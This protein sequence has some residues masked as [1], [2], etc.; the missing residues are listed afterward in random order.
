M[1]FMLLP[2]SKGQGRRICFSTDVDYMHVGMVLDHES[3]PFPCLTLHYSEAG[4]LSLLQAVVLEM[5]QTQR[6]PEVYLHEVAAHTDVYV[7]FQLPLRPNISR[8]LRA[9]VSAPVY[10]GLIADGAGV[11]VT[12][13]A[14]AEFDF[15]RGEEGFGLKDFL[16]FYRQAGCFY[17][18]VYDD[19]DPNLSPHPKE[20]R[21][22][23]IKAGLPPII[24]SPV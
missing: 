7:A 22:E 9:I 5:H 21:L 10:H 17:V 20:F 8:V 19:Q 11:E 14:A 13:L 3:H 23:T 6:K 16:D 1:E 12:M 2:G 24:L 18:G 4:Q 15:E